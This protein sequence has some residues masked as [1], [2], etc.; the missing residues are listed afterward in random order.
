M[1]MQFINQTKGDNS[2]THIFTIDLLYSRLPTVTR[3]QGISRSV[4]PDVHPAFIYQ[5]LFMRSSCNSIT[6]DDKYGSG[7]LLIH[8]EFNWRFYRQCWM[9]VWYMWLHGFKFWNIFLE[10][11]RN[12]LVCK[13]DK[14]ANKILSIKIFIFF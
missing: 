1:S 11:E 7:Q 8:V 3:I 14:N 12:G 2:N 4:L 6:V 13:I 10:I 5:Y 9:L